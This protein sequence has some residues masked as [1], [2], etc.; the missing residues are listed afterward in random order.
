M[1]QPK[2]TSYRPPDRGRIKDA[3][4]KLLPDIDPKIIHGLEWWQLYS[5]HQDIAK[6]K[7]SPASVARKYIKGA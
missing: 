6:D 2:S 3:V 1:S 5:I 7:K 4:A